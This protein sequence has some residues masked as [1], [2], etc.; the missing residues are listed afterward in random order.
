MNLLIRCFLILFSQLF[1]SPAFTQY[2]FYNE[3]YVEGKLTCEL[4]AE[5]GAMNC[6]TDLGGNKGRGKSFI[7]DLNAAQTRLTYGISGAINYKRILSLRIQMTKGMVSADDGAIKHNESAARGRNLRNL[8]FQS[9]IR[10]LSVLVEIYPFTL[11]AEEGSRLPSVDWYLFAGTGY[12]YFSPVMRLDKVDIELWDL[13]TEGQGFSEFPDR[14]MYRRKQFNLPMGT[15][16]K[17]EIQSRLNLRLELNYRKLFTDYLDDVSTGYIDPALFT[18]YLPPQRARLASD[19]SD[20]RIRAG[21]EPRSREEIRGNSQ[22]NDAF[23]S[24]TL[25]ASY[26]F[27]RQRGP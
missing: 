6:L 16:V 2:A 5:A 8:N 3:H 24:L 15:G 13:H 14:L 1:L 23:F 4:I 17:F 11:L 25:R 19:L 21:T 7:K 22:N 20:R 26:V 27:G 12:Y 18:K 10:E 9:N